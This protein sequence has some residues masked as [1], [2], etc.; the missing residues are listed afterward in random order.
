MGISENKRQAAYKYKSGHIK[1]VPLDMQ[2][3]EYEKLKS[4]AAASGETVNGYIKNAIRQ[5]MGK[6]G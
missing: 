1:R 2:I 5:R 4:A 3:E 6:N